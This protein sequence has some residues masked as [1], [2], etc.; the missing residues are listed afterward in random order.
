MARRASSSSSSVGA[1]FDGRWALPDPFRTPERDAFRASMRAFVQR[2]IAPFADE[3]DE[4]GAIPWAVHERAGAL[5]VWGFGIDE[6]YGG[7]GFDDAFLRKIYNE[8]LALC[9]AGGV[10]AAL[11]G[12]MIS[13]EP[14]ARLCGDAI[15]TR[16]LP[17]ILAG[18]AGSCLAITEPS[19]GS[20]VAATA[21]TATRDG[22]AYRLNGCK[23]FI[24]GGMTASYFVV[25][26]RTEGGL[27]LFFVDGERGLPDGMSRTPLERKMGWW[28][29]DQ[30][31]LYFEDCAVPAENR[32][33]AEGGGFASIVENSVGI[34]HG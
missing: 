9:G 13:V 19:G 5:G 27:S 3:W 4:A 11:N 14:I 12:R 8:E 34:N 22:G 21:A 18:T 29:A 7:L 24:T 15:R 6:A 1:A 20:D 2:E 16:A 32:M 31:T 17:R 30:A 28:C 23:T 26:A 33:G 10:A 25:G